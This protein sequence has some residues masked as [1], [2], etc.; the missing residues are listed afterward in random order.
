MPF[1]STSPNT[2]GRTGLLQPA[3]A[4]GMRDV[5]LL[6]GGG[7]NVG[8]TTAAAQLSAEL[9]AEHVEVDE[10]RGELDGRSGDPFAISNAWLR[11]VD[12]LFECLV[13]S[14]SRIADPLARL[15][16]RHAARGGA[17]IIE[18]QGIEPSVLGLIDLGFDVRAVFVIEADRNRI[19]TT[20][21]GRDSDGAARYRLLSPVEQQAVT[22]MNVRYGD[23]LQAEAKQHE[24]AWVASQPWP[25]LAHRILEAAGIATRG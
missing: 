15:I 3:A 16:D 2:L 6:I 17:A 21:R 10:L 5:V 18:G 9:G 11:P 19:E 13:E 25:T 8:K 24:L 20:L 1:V 4:T 22:T 14:T 23:W 7:S 12:E